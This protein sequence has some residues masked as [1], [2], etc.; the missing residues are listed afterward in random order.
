MV[1]SQKKR[2]ESA[3][4]PLDYESSSSNRDDVQSP[5]YSDISD[6]S[7][8]VVETEIIGNRT[9][10]SS[11]HSSHDDG[12]K[13]VFQF[14]DKT[15]PA[16]PKHPEVV[17]KAADVGPPTQL[18]PLGGFGMY[19]FYSQPPYLVQPPPS[20]HSNMGKS[21]SQ[22]PPGSIPPVGMV[23]DYNKIKEPPLDLMTKPSQSQNDTQSSSKDN[24][25]V[26]G[27]QQPSLQHLPHQQHPH[28]QQQQQQHQQQQQ[29]HQHPP[30]PSP[31][32]KF[33]SPYYP[34]K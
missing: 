13:R 3:G 33:I 6:D 8:P 30:P 27:S 15:Q 29:Q 22:P 1:K 26:L 12:T 32:N 10:A 17:K 24:I 4:V 34:Y 21:Q 2:K 9:T 25:G 28:Q 7:T 18:G 5:A 19:P 20:E 31:Q 23:Q 14:S 11:F 16:H